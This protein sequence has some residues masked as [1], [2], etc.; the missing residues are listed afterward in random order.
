MQL[1]SDEELKN[2]GVQLKML[3]KKCENMLGKNI[4]LIMGTL[5]TLKKSFK[6]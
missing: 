4:L 5:K 3:E 6:V 2:I 1:K